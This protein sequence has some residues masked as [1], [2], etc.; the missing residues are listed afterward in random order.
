MDDGDRRY[1]WRAKGEVTVSPRSWACPAPGRDGPVYG[2]RGRDQGVLAS[3]F[4]G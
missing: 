1:Q 2:M 4:G 3:A